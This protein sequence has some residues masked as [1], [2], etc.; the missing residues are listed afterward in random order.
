LIERVGFQW[1]I[2]L[3]ARGAATRHGVGAVAATGTTRA[4]TKPQPQSRK[5]KDDEAADGH[6]AK[7]RPDDDTCDGQYNQHRQ[8]GQ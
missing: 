4:D 2:T 7:S 8:Q 6:A 5:H 1:S 3:P